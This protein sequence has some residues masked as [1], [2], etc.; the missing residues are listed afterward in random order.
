MEK[1]AD[2]AQ[3]TKQRFDVNICKNSFESIENYKCILGKDNGHSKVGHIRLKN[4]KTNRLSYK[5]VLNHTGC[6]IKN[7]THSFYH[8]CS[9]DR[10]PS[11]IKATF[12][13]YYTELSF[14]VYYSFFGQ[15]A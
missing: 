7:G 5:N 10:N 6:A 12:I 4:F 8:S 2:V 3:K 15:L 9:H 1:R 13:C 14:K 11:S